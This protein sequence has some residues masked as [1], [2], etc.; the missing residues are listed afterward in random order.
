MWPPASLIQ[1][2]RSNYTASSNYRSRCCGNSF[3]WCC[4]VP[5]VSSIDVEAQFLNRHLN[6]IIF[7]ALFLKCTWR[8]G[9]P[10]GT[11]HNS[12]IWTSL[13]RLLTPKLAVLYYTRTCTRL[14]LSRVGDRKEGE[15]LLS[16]TF[17][18]TSLRDVGCALWNGRNKNCKVTF[19]ADGLVILDTSYQLRLNCSSC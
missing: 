11:S 3:F 19:A 13:L 9:I 2:D 1:Y 16:C 4:L 14:S 17:L 15:I 10:A 18:E 5:K 8:G 7:L 6:K 12:D